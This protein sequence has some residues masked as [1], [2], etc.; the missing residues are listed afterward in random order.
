MKQTDENRAN[1]KGDL[2]VVEIN[3]DHEGPLV[4]IVAGVHG[5]EYEPILA[6][7]GLPACIAG[8]LTKGRVRII[9]VV[10]RSAFLIGNRC[11]ID[12]LDL[13]RSCPGQWDGSPTMH[14]AAQV[15][16][17]IM[18]ADYLI[19]L[20]TGGQ[21]FDLYPL[22][23]YMLHPNQEVLDK[24]RQMAKAF[25]LP[26]VWGTDPAPE[27]R[28]LSIA[29]DHQIPAI[30]VEC[31]GPGPVR[32]A[33]IEAYRQGCLN[34]LYDLDMMEGT[35][36]HRPKYFI[37]DQEPGAGYLQ[38]KMLSPLEGIFVS[39]V[40]VGKEIKQGDLWGTVYDADELSPHEIHADTDGLVLYVR[41]FPK[42][43]ANESLGGILPL[44][45]KK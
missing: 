22:T 42:V 30:Y 44:N 5:D 32:P 38:G 19:D 26:L 24:Q 12:G 6:A 28:T 11:G 18:Q 41:S 40:A 3:S 10:N 43:K 39:A 20:H 33:T 7:A 8:C 23:G 4:L 13:A 27:G 36:R 29:R 15:S 37:E 25:G 16:Q 1:G 34:V 31:G 45:Q 2:Q 35:A 9:S 17:Q 21:L 14:Y